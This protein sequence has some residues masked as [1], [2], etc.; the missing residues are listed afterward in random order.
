MLHG[1]RQSAK[2]VQQL[3]LLIALPLC[4]LATTSCSSNNDKKPD[5]PVI[6]K[7]STPP[8]VIAEMP[9]TL[10]TEGSTVPGNVKISYSY[11]TDGDGNFET[12]P[13]SG[14]GGSLSYTFTE[15]GKYKVGVKIED[16][17]G[18]SSTDSIDFTV[19]PKDYLS[20]DKKSELKAVA[21][22]NN[23]KAIVQTQVSTEK[24]NMTMR[25]YLN[26]KTAKTA[27]DKEDIKIYGPW[28]TTGTETFTK[29]LDVSDLAPGK[30]SVTISSD[31]GPEKELTLTVK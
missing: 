10:S 23:L 13:E 7:I 24:A 17:T 15:T 11:D 14:Y 29:E 22:V 12:T 30:Y 31:A 26:G 16:E 27:V 6:A 25:V 28:E 19:Y 21:S 2:K 1:K 3:A 5:A 4:L 8:F 18:Q 9:T 20:A